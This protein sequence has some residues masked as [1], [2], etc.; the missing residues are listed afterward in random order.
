MAEDLQEAAAGPSG[1]APAAAPVVLVRSKPQRVR[2]GGQPTDAAHAAVSL[3]Q[4]GLPLRFCG[5]RSF[6]SGQPSQSIPCNGLF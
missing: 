3:T 1:D 4:T 2:F 5:Q 6:P